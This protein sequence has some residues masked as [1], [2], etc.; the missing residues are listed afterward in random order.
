MASRDPSP[1][2]SYIEDKQPDEDDVTTKDGRKIQSTFS[3]E[4]KEYMLDFLEDYL[5]STSS[6]ARGQKSK[7]ITKNVYPKYIDKFDSAG[8][9]GPNLSSLKTVS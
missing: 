9:N 3:D 4:Q 5:A 7:W 2:G 6:V 8:P 1:D